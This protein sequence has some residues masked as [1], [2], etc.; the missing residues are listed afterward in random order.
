MM[1]KGYMADIVLL[2]VTFIWGIMFVFV[3]QAVEAMPPLSYLAVRFLLA[4]LL[5]LLVWRPITGKG[6]RLDLAT[7][8]RGSLLGIMLFAGFTFQTIGLQHTT[9]AKAGFITGFNVVLVPILSTVIFRS[10]P[11]RMAVWGVAVAA[12]GFA[13]VSL[14]KTEPFQYGD[15]LVLIGAFAFAL[16]ILMTGRFTQEREHDAYSLVFVQL[17]AVSLLSFAGS[18]ATEPWQEGLSASVLFKPAV[19]RALVIGAVFATAF[20]YW[21]QTFFQRYTSATHTALIFSMEPVFA[22]AAAIVLSDERMALQ[23]AFG[24][25]LIFAGIILAE[26]KRDK[27]AEG[28]LTQS[29]QGNAWSGTESGRTA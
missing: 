19:I 6:K 25:A 28:A 29:T 5:I 1:K 2:F 11:S 18:F 27:K 14:D 15:A 21:A 24:C 4:A 22:A 10:K 13:V 7:V 9:V 26:F 17:A 23:T 20:A 3:K 16:H 12:C 8:K